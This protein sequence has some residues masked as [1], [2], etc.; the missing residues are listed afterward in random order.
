MEIEST[1]DLKLET[2]V[3]V[4]RFVPIKE[5]ASLIAEY[6]EN[7]SGNNSFVHTCGATPC[8]SHRQTIARL[9]GNGECLRFTFD[10]VAKQQNLTVSIGSWKVLQMERW[11]DAISLHYVPVRFVLGQ[12]DLLWMELESLCP[13]T[14]C[15]RLRFDTKPLATTIESKGYGMDTGS[16]GPIHLDLRD[17]PCAWKLTKADSQ[18]IHV[19][20]GRMYRR[21]VI[22]T[23][24]KTSAPKRPNPHIL[25]DNV[26]G[27]KRRVVT[28]IK[29]A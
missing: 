1:V 10:G 18:S 16:T 28:K 23:K 24:T 22:H 17:Q 27:C 29:K 26:R 25:Y 2:R 21:H 19:S 20:D 6:A 5:L 11:R 9:L 13:K 8:A 15:L 12:P 3:K 14:Y 4:F 7:N